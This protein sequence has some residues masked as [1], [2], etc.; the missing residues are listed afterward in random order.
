[1]AGVGY[2]RGADTSVLVVLEYPRGLRPRSPDIPLAS[3]GSVILPDGYKPPEDWHRWQDGS[4][5]CWWCGATVH[6]DTASIHDSWHL[7]L[8]QD[9][10]IAKWELPA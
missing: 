6:P 9:Q 8:E 3:G 5:C 1:M 4:T 7:R 2:R 10:P